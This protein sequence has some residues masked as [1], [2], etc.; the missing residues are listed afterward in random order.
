MPL[1][2]NFTPTPKQN[3]TLAALDNNDYEEILFGGGAGSGKT[4]LGCA[5]LI[6]SCL[7][8][9]DSRW[10]M[11]RAV[12]KRLKET[13]LVSFFDVANS[14]GLGNYYTYNAQNGTIIWHNG[15]IVILKDLASTPS[16]PD[17]D[18][19]GSLEICGAF[20][21]E[22]A[23]I[24]KKAKDVLLT[25][26]RYK[27]KVFNITPTV[28]MSCNP[29]KNFAYTQFYK[30]SKIG[31]IHPSRFFMSAL[32]SDN[33]YIPASYIRSLEKADEAIKQ[34]LLY[35]NWDFDNDP[36]IIMSYQAVEECFHVQP[37]V[38]NKKYITADIALEGDDLMVV[39]LWQGLHLI[40]SLVVPKCSGPEAISV[41]KRM[42]ATY[43][44]P[45]NRICY[46]SDGLGNYIKGYLPGSYAFKGNA[47]P[48]AKGDAKNLRSQC[49]LRLAELVELH[50]ISFGV[51]GITADEI[52]SE[53]PHIKRL[54]DADKP[55]IISKKDIKKTLG[56]STDYLD[57][58]MMRMVWTIRAPAKA[59]HSTQF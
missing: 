19:L 4:M 5:W 38:S 45:Y 8:Y 50:L 14:W 25:R 7:K 12:L 35:G 51:E 44:V 33:K 46:D 32:A 27:L 28:F 1:T 43:Q 54:P 53:A 41:L 49:F 42:A 3:L 34:R 26:C 20:L 13:T 21:D 31:T 6:M 55:T 17:F 52:L 10:V 59:S 36:Y 18:S 15:S 57:P 30:P 11:G 16:D 22:I 48:L 40:D 23:E 39:Y 24:S 47:R 56:H 29:T 58:L 2:I 9:P 37:Q